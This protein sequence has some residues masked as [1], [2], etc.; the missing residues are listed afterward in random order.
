[1]GPQVAPR[2]LST[3]T[4]KIREVWQDNLEAEMAIIRD[5]VDDYP[6][7]AM[8]TEFPGIVRP[9]ASVH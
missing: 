7:L 1:M 4:L 3:E 5:I 6:Y 9:I 2:A 8:D